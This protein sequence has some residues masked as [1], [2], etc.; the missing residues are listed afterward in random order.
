MNSRPAF[1]ILKMEQEA[2]KAKKERTAKY[3]AVLINSPLGYEVF[4]DIMNDL[5]V[6]DLDPNNVAANAL[7]NFGF[8]LAEVAGV[9]PVFKITEDIA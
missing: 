1:H 4:C 5:L 3:R 7:R 8:H 2:E 9:M 6:G